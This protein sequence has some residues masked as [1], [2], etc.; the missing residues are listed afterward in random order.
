M[1]TAMSKNSK[2]DK[3]TDNRMKITRLFLSINDVLNCIYSKLSR[4]KNI[5]NLFLYR[6]ETDNRMKIA[7][8]FLSN[9]D[10]L[11]CIY[12]KLSRLEDI[13]NLFLCCKETASKTPRVT[14]LVLE[15]LSA[16]KMEKLIASSIHTLKTLK[17]M[18]EQRKADLEIPKMNLS[19]LKTIEVRSYCS[20][21]SKSFEMPKEKRIC[22]NNFTKKKELKELTLFY[23]PFLTPYYRVDIRSKKLER[24]T[25]YEDYCFSNTDTMD[26]E[27]FFL[28]LSC[29]KNTKIDQFIIK[30]VCLFLKDSKKIPVRKLVFVTQDFFEFDVEYVSNFKIQVDDIS[31]KI[32]KLVYFGTLPLEAT[33]NVLVNL[34]MVNEVLKCIDKDELEEIEIKAFT[35]NE[36]EQEV[37]KLM[38]LTAFKK[39]KKV[40]LSLIIYKIIITYEDCEYPPIEDQGGKGYL[41]KISLPGCKVINFNTS[42]G[43]DIQEIHD[44]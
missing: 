1:K 34:Q 6:K 7:R 22:L 8:L 27:N 25:I 16:K 3:E 26:R 24:L 23:Q 28:S 39:L 15:E 30:N 29:D 12:S 17:I 36:N 41:L 11:N 14:S 13:R 40:K 9:N 18:I 19:N 42:K 43:L 35:W 20:F 31:I 2:S 33:K 44:H 5:R 10:V 32:V 37:L 38:N 4:L 21:F